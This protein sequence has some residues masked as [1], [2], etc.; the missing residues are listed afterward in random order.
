MHMNPSL[1]PAD[2]YIVINKSIITEEDKKILNMLYL[3]ITGAL[4]IMLYNILLTNLDKLQITSDI[5][6][7]AHLL[8][9][10][11]ISINE[12]EE[13][14]RVLEAIG[15]LK[16]YVK[17]G[18]INNYVYQLY[19]PCSAHEFVNNPILNTSLYNN[20][21]KIEYEKIISYF[22]IPKIN[23]T[24]YEE[25]TSNFSDVFDVSSNNYI[26]FE[27]SCIK[28]RYNNPLKINSKIDLDNIFSLIPDE[29]FNIRS[30]TKDVKDLI[31]KLSF[32][33]N[34]NEDN[35]NELA[36]FFGEI[37][38][39]PPIDFYFKQFELNN[40][41]VVALER[42]FKKLK[43]P[44]TLDVLENIPYYSNISQIIDAYISYKN[45]EVLYD[46]ELEIEEE[47]ENKNRKE[48]D[49]YFA[50]PTKAYLMEIRRI[51]LLKVDE[52]KELLEKIANGDSSA[53]DKFI[54]GRE[55]ADIIY[56]IKLSRMKSYYRVTK[57]WIKQRLGLERYN[58]P[59]NFEQLLYYYSTVRSFYKKEKALLKSL[60]EYK[61]KVVFLNKREINNILKEN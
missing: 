9:N 31:Y 5:E 15:L 22:K 61:D 18:S 6:T 34:L 10:L 25:I 47:K 51:P 60:E 45:I 8:S 39:N 4:P 58:Y 3:P 54:E 42:L 32:I 53:R 28:R 30:L 14:R 1:L 50:D 41:I 33:Y 35:L 24:N 52:E 38:F 17:K 13:A 37:S 26:E 56:Y 44:L 16:T 43:S 2:S 29:L 23:L 36:T 40:K 46:S 20:V 21:G 57:R 27:T 7:H 48:N 11:H 19:S 55:Q 12:L 59:P 49:F